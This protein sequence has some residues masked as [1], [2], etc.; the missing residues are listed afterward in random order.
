MKKQGNLDSSNRV[1]LNTPT[2]K[3]AR[4]IPWVIFLASIIVHIVS[5]TIFRVPAIYPDEFGVLAVGNW[6]YGGVHWGVVC[7]FYYGYTFSLFSGWVFHLSDNAATIYLYVLIIKS[8]LIS[9]IPVLCYKTLDETLD[10]KE[11]RIKI[12]LSAMVSLYPAFVVYSKGVLNETMLHLAFV[13]CIYLIAKCITITFPA[14]EDNMQKQ[15]N[16]KL[17]FRL[18]S[19]LLGFIIVFAYAS[20]GIGLV[21]IIAVCLTI[22]AAY[23]FTKRHIVS[24]PFFTGS[25]VIFLFIDSRVKDY[26]INGYYRA[27]DELLQNT[28]GDSINSMLTMLNSEGLRLFIRSII[29]RLHYLPSAT[30]GVFILACIV[31]S[32][33]IKNLIKRKEPAST[34]EQVTALVS[35]FAGLLLIG[36]IVVSSVFLLESI[37]EFHGVFYIYGRYYEYMAL[38]LIMLG[39]YRILLKTISNKQLMIYSGISIGI[40][41]GLTIFMQVFVVPHFTL[42]DMPLPYQPFNNYGVLPFVGDSALFTYNTGPLATVTL[43][44]FIVTVLLLRTKHAILAPLLLALMFVYSS[45]YGILSFALPMSNIVYTNVHVPLNTVISKY[46]NTDISFSGNEPDVYVIVDISDFRFLEYITQLAFNRHTLTD[47]FYFQDWIEEWNEGTFEFTGDSIILSES[48]LGL[49][50][51]S[52]SFEKIVSSDGAYIW[53]WK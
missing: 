30:F 20:H 43:L 34:S 29:G 48:D 13:L 16:Q 2:I 3:H 21:Y 28:L 22:L 44:V 47:G 23:L 25:L 52:N 50:N 36:S 32:I 1:T 7:E 49:E 10:I 6:L 15:I 17:K 38:P 11:T 39:L 24:Y 37:Q 40:Y 33:F 18:Y 5:S 41:L 9:F 42:I 35:I 31:L 45:V 53:L 19:V 27:A 51:I 26:I 8:V 4:F 12:I 46:E 14:A